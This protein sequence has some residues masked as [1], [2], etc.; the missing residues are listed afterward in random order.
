MVAMKPDQVQRQPANARQKYLIKAHGSPRSVIEGRVH[1]ASTA[2]RQL[3]SVRVVYSTQP[4]WQTQ[5]DTY[6]PHRSLRRAELPSKVAIVHDWLT[7]YGGAER[8]L[9]QIL[10]IA[11]HADVFALVDFLPEQE[12]CF[13]GGRRPATSF[14]QHMPFAKRKYR[15]Y[16]PV[17]PH[18]IEQFDLSS[19][20]LVISSSHAVAKGVLTGPDQLHISYVH[21]PARYAWDLSHQY[22]RQSGLTSGL[23]S[24]AARYLLHQL[25]TWDVRCANGVDVYVANS[26]F[27]ARRIWKFYRREASV[28]YPPV[29]VSRFPLCES[30]E[31]FYLTASRLVPY[32]RVDLVVETFRKMP[33]R[34]LVV[35]GD[36]PDFRRISAD[37]PPNVQMVGFQPQSALLDYMQRARAFIIAAEE[38]FGIA[39]LEAQACGTPVIAFGKGGVL[40]TVRGL[41]ATQ[42]TGTF[43]GEQN[44]DSLAAAI[45]EFEAY[46]DDIVPQCCRELAMTFDTDRFRS[47]FE[48]LIH[49]EFAEF[50][51]RRVAPTKSR[52]SQV[53]GSHVLDE[54]YAIRVRANGAFLR[55]EHVIEGG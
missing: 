19:Y 14:I 29:D 42:P 49:R 4:K 32:K 18:A 44:V 46:R 54:D 41:Q 38:D 5:C 12:R 35:V 17:M 15:S 23:R 45:S 48:Q 20:P 25:R 37:A 8:V 47:T 53:L 21:S 28:V 9:E 10:L 43:F 7:V 6:A 24:L 16:L 30:K 40:E 2:Q 55:R 11:P 39:P 36:G 51:R 52:A 13:L 26:E 33:D 34:R 1:E 50:G 31:D 27:I 3:A 22:L